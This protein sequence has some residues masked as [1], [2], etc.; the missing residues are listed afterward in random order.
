MLNLCIC[1]LSFLLNTPNKQV[2]NVKKYVTTISRR[3]K[4]D[5]YLLF[6]V[7]PPI[8]PPVI[9]PVFPGALP[10]RPAVAAPPIN[11]PKPLSETEFLEE[12]NRLLREEL[13]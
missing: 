7:R 9:P 12:K 10:P 8:V 6:S 11:M 4:M 5:K 13:E 2:K 1:I 3:V